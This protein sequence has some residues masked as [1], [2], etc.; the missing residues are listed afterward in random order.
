MS[1]K[2]LPIEVTATPLQPLGMSAARFLRDYW[3]KRPLLIRNALPGYA[4]AITPNDLAGLACEDAAL[5]RIVRHQPRRDRWSVR[6]G[7]FS[8]S[9][10]SRLPQTHWT[11][12]VQDVDKWDADVAA[13]LGQF[14]FLP[15]WRIDDI[16]VSYAVAGGGVGAHFDQYDVFLLQTRGVRR[17]RI[18]TDANA[19]RQLRGDAPLRLLSWF[20]PNHEWDLHPGDMLYLPPGLPHEGMA[21]DK[22]L[23]FSI[24]MRAPSRAEMLLDC[25][26][27]LAE[28]LCEDDRYVDSDLQPVT[29]AHQ[30]D[31]RALARVRQA[32]PELFALEDARLADW[33]GCF[34]TRYRS[35]HEAAPAARTMNAAALR[36]ALPRCRLLRNPFSRIAWLQT[37][38]TARLFVAGNGYGPCPPAFAKLLCA[39]PV[40]EGTSLQRYAAGTAI[41]ILVNL[42]NAGHL[43]LA[44]RR[45]RQCGHS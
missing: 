11:L 45:R 12:L 4:D 14:T 19:P 15:A 30:I 8:E 13:V 17:W 27:Y 6:H 37:G 5:S 42:L 28:P 3:Q 22:C 31:N 33:F 10:F 35:A 43:R 16:M 21:L 40:T 23:T 24:G 25:A 1:R 32:M 18:D 29:N 36:R 20:S 9:D 34:I 38:R 41:D 39:Q 26:D 7:P 2:S 44:P